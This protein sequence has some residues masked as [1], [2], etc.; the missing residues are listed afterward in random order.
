MRRVNYFFFFMFMVPC[1][2]NLNCSKPT[3]CNGSQTILFFAGSLYMFRVLSTPIIRSTKNCHYSLRYRSYYCSSYLPPTW[4]SWPR[5]RKVTAKIIWPVPEAVF[6]VLCT[7]D[8]GCGQH[9][10]HV[11]WSC[12]KIKFSA[13]SCISLVYYNISYCYSR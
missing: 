12:S 11:K 3:R 13:N 4:Q 8:D 7:P 9:P 2:M 5:W 6:T 10:K 1:I